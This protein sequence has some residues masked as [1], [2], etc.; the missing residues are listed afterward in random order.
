M[1]KS[2]TFSNLYKSIF[3]YSSI[4]MGQSFNHSVVMPIPD[5]SFHSS[6]FYGLDVLEQMDFKPLYDKSIGIFTNKTAVNRKGDH[7]L[8][9]LKNH[10]K[11]DVKVIFTPQFGL[12]ADQNK[13][14]KMNNGEKYD[15]DHNARLVEVFGRNMKPPAWSVRDLDMVIID[16]Q[17]TGVR[18][19][20]YISTMTKILEVAS[21]WSLPVIILDRPNPLRGDRV[22]GPVIRSK[23]QS[24]EG[25]HII[26]IRHGL[27]IG[28]L[29]I[30]A[31]EMGWIKDL[32]R[33]N[34]TII[35]MANWKRSHWLDNSEHPWIDP[36]PSIHSIRSNL[37]Y[38]GFGLLEGTNL[39]DG[40]GTEMPFMRAGAPWMSGYHLAD[41]LKN[42]NLPG[43]SIT[44][45]DYIP[46]MK[47]T[48]TV[49]PMYVDE[50]CS[51]IDVKIIDPN[52]YDPIATATSIIVLASQ[53]YPREFK[54]AEFDRIDMLY[55]HSQLRLFSAQ[56]KP[57]N[58]L[59]PLWL[60]DVI[61]FNQFRQRFLIY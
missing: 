30:M 25:Y 33:A 40:R 2:S 43:V 44:P 36:H 11:I 55:G 42:L 21:E 22:D 61:K 20:T 53:L 24:L 13:R 50:L 16:I 17:D 12:F 47:Q 19:S 7:I 45:I 59:P 31:N 9:L 18:F 26:P 57:A 58:Y 15:P 37:S 52:T 3:L 56:G 60:K 6:T 35:P 23:F 54:W 38:T 32:K 48:D 46:R 8:D 4:A 1:F 5:L 34:L 10:S 27:T 51:G 39:N 28:E 49:A 41:K 29:A 14:F